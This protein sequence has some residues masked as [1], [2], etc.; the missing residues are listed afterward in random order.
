MTATETARTGTDVARWLLPLL[1]EYTDKLNA[2]CDRLEQAGP[3][4][5]STS[6]L[7]FARVVGLHSTFNEIL[8]EYLRQASA[9]LDHYQFDGDE[10]LKS[11]LANRWQE[12]EMAIRVSDLFATNVTR[13]LTQHKDRAPEVRKL[14]KHIKSGELLE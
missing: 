7:V 3:L 4:Y 1:K 2:A 6:S 10:D 14:I 8:L 5:L 9:L 12:A 11:E 13:L